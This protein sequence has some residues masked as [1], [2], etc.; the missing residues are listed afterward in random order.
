MGN[1][2]TIH[3]NLTNKL[4]LE[5]PE[6][7]WAV[8]I[9]PNDGYLQKITKNNELFYILKSNIGAFNKVFI[10]PRPANRLVEIFH[11]WEGM[12]CFTKEVD[13]SFIKLV[14]TI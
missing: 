2:K 14:G 8:T 6:G 12:I 11:N 7:R 13:P 4:L 3:Q 9:G 5:L 1:T 10:T